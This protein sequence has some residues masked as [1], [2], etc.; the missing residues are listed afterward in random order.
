MQGFS[1]EDI[2]DPFGMLV[3]ALFNFLEGKFIEKYGI[4]GEFYFSII[5]QF[6]NA[7]NIIITEYPFSLH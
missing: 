1:P 4:L 6:V 2:P 3:I 7:Y 5:E